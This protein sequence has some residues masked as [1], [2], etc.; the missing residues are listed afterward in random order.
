MNDD[1]FD[2]DLEAQTIDLRRHLSVSALPVDSTFLI[3]GWAV[4]HGGVLTDHMSP[5][6]HLNIS[7]PHPDLTPRPRGSSW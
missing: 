2:R 3:G 5:V 4:S 1:T 6:T 7:Q